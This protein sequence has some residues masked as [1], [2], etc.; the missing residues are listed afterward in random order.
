MKE[1]NRALV[2]KMRWKVHSKHDNLW[3]SLFKTKYLTN[4]D[5]L[6]ALIQDSQEA[7][8]RIRKAS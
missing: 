3:V 8:L 1:V 6:Y 5:L 7:A 2:S 4:G